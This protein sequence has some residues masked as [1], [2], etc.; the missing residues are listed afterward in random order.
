MNTKS[1]LRQFLTLGSLVAALTLT[2]TSAQA[3]PAPSPVRSLDSS[4]DRLL[5]TVR[6]DYDDMGKRE[7]SSFRGAVDSTQA[8]E[9]AVD[10]LRSAVENHS[11]YKAIQGN[12]SAVN[13][14]FSDVESRL[15]RRGVSREA[16][17]DLARSRDALN[18]TNRS[19]SGGGRDD[20]NGRG[21]RDDH[22]KGVVIRLH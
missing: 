5:S 22:R 16:R 9:N 19:L 3:A 7:R 14:E 10:R 8:L 13:S 18:A 20:H 1:K 15:N 2:A 11:S 21:D 12:L 17:A 4:T 6:A